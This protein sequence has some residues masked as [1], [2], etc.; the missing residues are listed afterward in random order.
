MVLLQ[1]SEQEDLYLVRHIL[2]LSFILLTVMDSFH[3]PYVV[4]H[5]SYPHNV[6]FRNVLVL[7]SHAHPSFRL[8][9]R[10]Q[11]PLSPNPA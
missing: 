5:C 10:P 1:V 3:R 9:F 7:D 4:V 2:A 8:L 6:T 11:P